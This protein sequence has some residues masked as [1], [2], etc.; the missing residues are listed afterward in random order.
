MA[1]APVTTSSRSTLKSAKIVFPSA[2][3]KVIGNGPIKSD[4]QRVHQLFP[5]RA[6]F[7]LTLAF[8]KHKKTKKKSHLTKKDDQ[9]LEE[10]TNYA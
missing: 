10:T 8:Q 1:T 2:D 6:Y 3:I 4:G 9:S 7:V 5:I